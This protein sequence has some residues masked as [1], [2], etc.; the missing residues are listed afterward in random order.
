MRETE[1]GGQM[2][3][4]LP[5]PTSTHPNTHYEP[6]DGRETEKRQTDT[7]FSATYLHTQS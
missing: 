4:A 6:E 1:S 3:V 7:N 2:H 5:A